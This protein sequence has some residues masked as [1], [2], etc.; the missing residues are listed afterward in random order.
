MPPPDRAV[1][2]AIVS[3]LP[4][5]FRASYQN[6]LYGINLFCRY[7]YNIFYANF[8]TKTMFLVLLAVYVHCAGDTI[9]ESVNFITRGGGTPQDR[10]KW[11]QK[12]RQHPEDTVNGNYRTG[13]KRSGQITRPITPHIIYIVYK[14]YTENDRSETSTVHFLIKTRNDYMGYRIPVQ[15]RR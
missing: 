15:H 12:T 8:I 13:D 1:S 2:S 3:Y 10:I 9:E 5:Y 6:D 4:I 7:I 11:D 14:I